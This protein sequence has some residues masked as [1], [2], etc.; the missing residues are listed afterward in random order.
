MATNDADTGPVELDPIKRL[1]KDLKVSAKLLGRHEARFLVDTYY[2]I[3]EFRIASA[4]QVRSIMKQPD[5]AVDAIEPCETI[6]WL[7]SNMTALENDIKKA[8]A[9]FDNE[10]R[11]GQWLQCAPPE[12]QVLV[13][14]G[15]WSSGKTVAIESLTT[16]DNV[17][18]F[19]RRH[20]RLSYPVPVSVASRP[21]SG[22]MVTVETD[23]NRTRTTPNHKWLVRLEA[24]DEACVVYMMRQGPRFRIG[25]TKAIR[26]RS[27]G[28]GRFSLRSR[29][30]CERA[31]QSWILKYFPTRREAFIYEAAV[32]ARYGLP[33]TVFEQIRGGKHGFWGKD[34]IDTFYEMLEPNSQLARAV[35]CLDDHGQL[36]DMPML[37]DVG[38]GTKETVGGIVCYANNLIP[39]IMSI[40]VPLRGGGVEWHKMTG[41]SKAHYDG[42]V[43]S[44]DVPKHHKYIQDGMATCNSICGIGPVI[45][46]GLLSTLDVRKCKTA[47][48]FWRFAG[49]DPTMKWEKGQKRPW[50]ARLKCLC[51]FKV[52][53]SFVKVQG[54]EKDFYGK[55]F[56]ERKAQ[57]TDGNVRG[58]YAERAKES[59]AAKNFGKE[60]EARKAYEA[61]HL[62]KAHIHARARRWTV[63]LFL[64]HVHHAMYEDYFGSPPPVPYV[65]SHCEG[66]HRHYISPPNWPWSKGGR[67]LT[68]LLIDR[69]DAPKE[70]NEPSVDLDASDEQDVE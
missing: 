68:E 55:L 38:Y 61:G 57:E 70:P 34:E 29:S 19:D 11:I 59:L 51:A 66:D 63:K 31:D 44:L 58:N 20:A 32:A 2:Q 43:Y 9:A 13:Q 40:P 23:S 21:Y 45:T 36:L 12:S 64:S 49:L 6:Q 46:A 18:P 52:G 65:F 25:V 39:E 24:N 14:S 48:H 22:Q 3:Q 10:W 33:T 41:I 30:R 15:R 60:T 42:P 8:L 1:S 35:Q 16:G 27:Q 28:N 4:G 69:P 47:G 56:A 50:N 26:P 67:P 7:Q 17:V 62:P 37:T 5:D 54:R 53:E